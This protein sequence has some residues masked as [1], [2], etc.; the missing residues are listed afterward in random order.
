MVPVAKKRYS[1]T[2]RFCPSLHTRAMACCIGTFS[3]RRCIQQRRRWMVQLH[4]VVRMRRWA[5]AL[6]CLSQAG[7]QSGSKRMSRDAPTKLIP[8]PPA[9]LLSRK[10]NCRQWA[11]QDVLTHSNVDKH[12][13]RRHTP[14]HPDSIA[15]RTPPRVLESIGKEAV[16]NSVVVGP[17]LCRVF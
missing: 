10:A 13:L 15:H 5:A 2:R 9:L 8:H 3:S 17:V 7:F 12:M 16:T 11:I 6:T 1:K 14:E 4:A